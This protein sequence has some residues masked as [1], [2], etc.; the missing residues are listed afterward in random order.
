MTPTS[1]QKYKHWYDVLKQRVH[2]WSWPLRDPVIVCA[3]ALILLGLALIVL[4]LTVSS[5]SALQGVGGIV[6]G[7]GLTVLLSQLT[8]RQQMAKD[9]ELW[10]KTN[11]YKPLHAELQTLRERLEAT[12]MGA[13]PYLQWIDI[14]GMQFP[15]QQSAEEPPQLQCWPEF[16]TD[17]RSSLNF[18][19]RMSLLLNQVL[20]LAS[21]YNSAMKDALTASENIFATAIDTAITRTAMSEAYH[22][23][24]R[25]HP[26]GLAV[27][28]ASW[29]SQDWL[30]R[31]QLALLTPSSGMAW[32]TSWLSSG[33]MGHYR[34]PTL[35]WLLAKDPEQ[36]VRCIDAVCNTPAGSYP[37][38][39]SEWLQAIR[40]EVWSALQGHPTYATVW[41]LHEELFDQVSQAETKLLNKLRDIQNTYEG[42]PPSL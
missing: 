37:P 13:K 1:R 5:V 42:G 11:L 20:Q 34:P 14:P 26:S 30:V 19:E 38:P 28:S 41:R 18:S 16:K 40:D 32:A 9:A 35:G 8:N 6:L 12:R 2:Y 24:D 10:R 21:D 31:I 7:T 25:D 3:L 15:V 39:P 33:P 29:S 36:A 17:S 4:G 27:G 23:W 22:Q